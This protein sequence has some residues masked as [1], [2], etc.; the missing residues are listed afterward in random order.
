MQG[1]RGAH[2]TWRRG[3]ADFVTDRRL[4]SFYKI[5]VQNPIE[6]LIDLPIP[7]PAE[8]ADKRAN[9][10]NAVQLYHAHSNAASFTGSEEFVAYM[11]KHFA[12]LDTRAE[13]GAGD[14]L[15]IW[16]RTSGDLAKGEI[17]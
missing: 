14:V 10:F 2:W 5:Q 1:T 13:Q 9:C 16:S 12:Q 3:F 6:E 17:A 11:F 8:I 4:E 7:L 15:I